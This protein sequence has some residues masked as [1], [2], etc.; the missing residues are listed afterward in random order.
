MSVSRV[1]LPLGTE[2]LRRH[3]GYFTSDRDDPLFIEYL[4]LTPDPDVT[5]IMGVTLI[6]GGTAHG[7]V[8]FTRGPTRSAFD[9]ADLYL[10]RDLAT[11]LGTRLRVAQRRADSER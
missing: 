8:L 3:G 1:A 11:T 10:L 9:I 2:Q 7:E 6:S 5:A 4:T